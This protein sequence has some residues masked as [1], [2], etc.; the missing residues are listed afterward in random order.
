MEKQKKVRENIISVITVILGNFIYALA[1]KFFLIPGGLVTGGSTG[2][3]L[4]LHHFFALPVS[5]F[6]LIF[7]MI[8]LIVGFLGLGKKF[9]LTTI[10]SSFAYPLSLGFL[11]RVLGD[12]FVTGDVILNTLFAGLGIGIAVGMVIRTGASTGGMDIPPLI[13]KKYMGIPVS[14]SLYVFDTCILLSQA[15]VS[16]IEKLL[17][18]CVLVFIY[19]TV[20][21]RVLLMGT[22]HTEMKIISKK[23]EEVKR[24]IIQEMDRGITILNGRGGY[25]K[26]D[27]EVILTVVSGREVPRIEKLIHS[28]DDEAFMTFSKVSEVRGRGFSMKKLYK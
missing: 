26:K 17:Y 15:V 6:V 12:V 23:P 11:D 4:T 16:D 22:T 21:D 13:L 3:A 8:M 20:I 5:V 25:L 9:A 7:N 1:V 28:I 19:T 2:I 14:V 18:G 10:L 24:A 27:T